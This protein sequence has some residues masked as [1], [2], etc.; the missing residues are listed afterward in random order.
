MPM[1]A[2]V[3]ELLARTVVAFT[4]PTFIG[5]FGICIASPVA[6][7]S[8]AIP[9]AFDYKRKIDILLNDKAFSECY[10]IDSIE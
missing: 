8:A 1:M 5:Y 9:L 10:S 6:W 4:L 2:G 3:Y 7:F